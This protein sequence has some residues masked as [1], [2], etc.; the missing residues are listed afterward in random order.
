MALLKLYTFLDPE[1]RVKATPVAT[2]DERVRALMDDMIETM[3]H[4]DGVGLS[5]TQVG[6]K[7]RIAVMDWSHAH[8]DVKSIKMAN[9]EI[10]WKSTETQIIMDGCLSVPESFSQTTRAARVKYRYL[11]EDNVL[12]EKEAEGMVAACVQHEID[13]LDGILF[14]D[15]LSRLRRKMVISK[16]MKNLKR[17]S[18]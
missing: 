4:H 10:T 8:P 18:R 16:A 11:N 13:H 14:I 5:A 7:E 1:V 2:V 17:Q 9:P 6:L 12:V 3:F 15:H